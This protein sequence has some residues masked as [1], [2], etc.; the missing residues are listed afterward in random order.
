MPVIE[1]KLGIL[2]AALAVAGG[3]GMWAS[4]SV[5]TALQASGIPIDGVVLQLAGT[6]VMIGLAFGLLRGKVSAMQESHERERAE[7]GSRFDRIDRKLDEV[8]G[9]VAAFAER[10]NHHGREIDRLR[11]TPQPRRGGRQPAADE[12]DV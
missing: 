12:E 9:Q 11:D 8:S 4:E 10:L 2:A 3:V 6:A 1:T 5:V 7:H